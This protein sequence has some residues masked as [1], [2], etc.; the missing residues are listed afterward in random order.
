M[1]TLNNV[2]LLGRLVKDPEI[3]M[4]PSGKKVCSFTIANNKRG[5]D[6]NANFFDCTAWEQKAE[7][8][9]KYGSKGSQILISGRLDQQ[10]WEKDGK[11]QSRIM[12]I[13]DDVQLLSS[14]SKKEDTDFQDTAKDIPIDEI[15]F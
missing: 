5:K 13:A 3:K 10:S 14:A 7:Y 11:K 1:A 12:I 2:N 9:T 6:E 4:T 8:L 15:P